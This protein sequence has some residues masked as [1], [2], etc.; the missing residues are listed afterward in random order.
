MATCGRSHVSCGLPVSSASS[1][2]PRQ[3]GRRCSSIWGSRQPPVEGA[4]VNV[5]VGCD[6]SANVDSA[7]ELDQGP[8]RDPMLADDATWGAAAGRR[9]D[10]G[11]ARSGHRAHGAGRAAHAPRVA[12]AGPGVR[13]PG[14][15]HG[16][17]W[18][19]AS[20]DV[21]RPVMPAGVWVG[22]GTRSPRASRGLARVA[23]GHVNRGRPAVPHRETDLGQTRENCVGRDTRRERGADLWY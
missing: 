16:T 14:R 1:L 10:L 3:S 22:H 12:R 19:G 4:I 5:L 17:R 9:G 23:M 21:L 13:A 18:A 8:V 6:L 15:R 20:R 2:D 11:G 7:V